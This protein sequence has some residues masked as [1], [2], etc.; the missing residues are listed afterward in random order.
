MPVARVVR[1]WI[2]AG[3]PMP[4][5]RRLIVSIALRTSGGPAAIRRPRPAMEREGGLGSS[6][7]VRMPRGADPFDPGRR[8]H[9][10]GPPRLSGPAWRRGKKRQET[11]AGQK[12]GVGLLPI[13]RADALKA[14][15]AR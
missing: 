12:K 13:F 3:R 1:R 7:L 15:S 2:D 9:R 6:R 11:G 4:R 10:D 5:A 8:P 14:I